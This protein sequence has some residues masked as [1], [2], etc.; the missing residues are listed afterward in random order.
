MCDL[1][2]ELHAQGQTIVLVTHD[3]ALAG[4]LATRTVGLLDGRT[5]TPEV[6]Q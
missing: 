1:F 5:V 3:L 6:A 2:A 4:T